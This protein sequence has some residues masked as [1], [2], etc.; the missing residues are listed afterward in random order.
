MKKTFN[1]IMALALLSAPLRA[2]KLSKDDLPFGVNLAGGEFGKATGIYGKD[3]D[4]P[5]SADL[6]YFN[7]KGMRLIRL[8][9]KW[10]RVQPEL[11]GDFDPEEL[12]RLKSVIEN[13]EKKGIFI[14]PD[15]HNY[16][17]RN[18]GSKYLI[19]GDDPLTI[20]HLANFWGRLAK[21]LSS[22]SNIYGYGL[23]NEPHDMLKTA[24]WF[25]MAQACIIEI[26]KFDVK[27]AIMI[28]GNSWSS[29]ERWVD[30]SDH[31][32]YLYDPSSKLIFE[33]HVYFDANASGIYKYSYDEEHAQPFTGVARVSP[34]VKWLQQNNFQGFIGEYGIP[35]DDERW[36][37]CLRNFLAYL[38]ANGVNG[39]YWA[40]GP[41]W[42]N[43][44]LSVQPENDFK[45]DKP[46]L[47]TL[48]E[49]P[50]APKRKFV[51]EK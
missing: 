50:N 30:A 31:L 2:Q 12:S 26:R 35:G 36:Q 29:A 7:S 37:V 33:A 45:K 23:M 39:T 25:K 17:R 44:I 21:E 1:V 34:F 27:T 22:Y 32:K 14:I 42:R 47:K 19:I 4:Y 40:A 6:D 15:L 8:P 43:Y 11:N 20:A 13:A 46:Q 41:L 48:Q 38:Q 24:P 28:G 10:E 49:F 16:G 3:Y 51:S 18:V 9:F 5:S